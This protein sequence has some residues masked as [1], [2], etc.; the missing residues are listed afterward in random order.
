MIEIQNL[1][2][3]YQEQSIFNGINLE[4]KHGEFCAVVGGNGSGKSTLLKL[5][6][7]L[8]VPS[9]GHVTVFGMDTQKE[10]LILEIR[11]KIGFVFQNP[12]NQIIASTVLE[13]VCFGM[14]NLGFSREIMTEKLEKVLT[15]TGLKGL[16]NKNPLMLSGGQKQR[17]AIASSIVT[18]PEILLMDEPLSM[19]D[20]EG[21][22]DVFKLIVDFHQS[23]KTVLL[24]THDMAVASK[25]NRII[26]LKNGKVELSGETARVL[27]KLVKYEELNI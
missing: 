16:E 17:L 22:R 26:F 14:E 5:I 7:G 25:T 19:L 24:V 20:P 23:N 15:F 3:N 13:D 11:K 6:E 18:D 2:F 12:E 10:D 1:R 4:I 27:P 9:S 8:L 21:Q